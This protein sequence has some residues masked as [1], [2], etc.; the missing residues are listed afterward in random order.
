MR[1][2]L[3][4]GGS[5]E[6]VVRTGKILNVRDVDADP[7]I[8]DESRSRYAL[9]GYDVHSLMVAPVIGDDGS[10]VGLIELVNK[11]CES[12]GASGAPSPNATCR[13]TPHARVA[14]MLTRPL[15]ASLAT[16]TQARS[17]GATRSTVSTNTTSA[18]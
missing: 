14:Q 5:R 10:V 12:P 17:C 9:R 6:K 7:R 3:R 8:T 4:P 1:L 11:E 2:R 18:C 13:R 16:A 15:G